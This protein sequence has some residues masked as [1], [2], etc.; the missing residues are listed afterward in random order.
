VPLRGPKDQGNFAWADGSQNNVWIFDST[1]NNLNRVFTDGGNAYAFGI[2]GKSDYFADVWGQEATVDGKS[3]DSVTLYVDFPQRGPLNDIAPSY[4]F[5]TLLL[6]DDSASVSG[7][8]S[9]TP[10]R[11]S[12]NVNVAGAQ[13]FPAPYQGL[14]AFAGSSLIGKTIQVGFTETSMFPVVIVGY[15][16]LVNRQRGVLGSSG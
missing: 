9:S 15:G 14:T 3:A 1:D 5:N 13:L 16:I 4:T 10:L 12:F 2:V 11:A 8:V 7:S 6:I